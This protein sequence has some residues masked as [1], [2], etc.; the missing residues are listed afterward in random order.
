MSYSKTSSV[1]T[2][3]HFLIF[4]V[5][6]TALVVICLLTLNN[7]FQ[8]RDV[9]TSKLNETQVIFNKPVPSGLGAAADVEIAP[10]F[11]QTPLPEVQS[12]TS[13][14]SNTKSFQIF[15]LLAIFS[16]IGASITLMLRNMKDDH[17]MKAVSQLHA[18]ARVEH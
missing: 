12:A 4:G 15:W 8:M 10:A 13:T 1:T 11:Q 18:L 16:V 14:S 3:N 6:L 17:E 5:T 7:F 2:Q 9:N